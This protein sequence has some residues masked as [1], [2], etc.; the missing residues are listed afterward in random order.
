M[1]ERLMTSRVRVKI[2]TLLLVH[3]NETYYIRQI[4]RLIAET[5]N[6]V[7]SELIN[8]AD[9]GI[10]L[11]EPKANATFYRANEKHFLYG[12]LKRMI[13]KTVAFGD[14]IAEALSELG[15]INVAFIYGSVAKNKETQ[16]SDVDLLVIGN[17]EVDELDSVVSDIEE[18]LCRDVNYTVFSKREWAEKVEQGQTFVNDVLSNPKV[19]LIGN[20]YAL[21]AIG[22]SRAD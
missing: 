13:L 16:S 20:E 15:D 4:S 17:V 3:P 11:S 12:E 19:F 9:L 7:R 10:V 18:E 1:L 22:A 21:S 8:L 2:L 5:Y 6:N 14:A